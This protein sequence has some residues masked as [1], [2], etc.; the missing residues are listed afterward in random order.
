MSR[1]RARRDGAG[2]TRLSLLSLTELAQP[3]TMPAM[4]S[5]QAL[6]HDLG[7]LASA[8]DSS[9]DANPAVF[10]AGG[11]RL[12]AEFPQESATG[13]QALAC[14][15]RVPLSLVEAWL[16][17][18]L[19]LLSEEQSDASRRREAGLATALGGPAW[20]KGRTAG[21]WCE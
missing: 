14:Q 12:R 6:G 15:L 21:A 3:D 7:I 13:R 16:D 19:D 8:L 18:T 20:R 9:P 1:P 5:L 4:T 2:P 11:G 10:R 17:D